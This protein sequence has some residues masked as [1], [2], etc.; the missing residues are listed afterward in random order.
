MD[1]KHGDGEVWKEGEGGRGPPDEMP[2]ATIKV[3]KE[4]LLQLFNSEP[5]LELYLLSVLVTF[6]LLS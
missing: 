1:L 6:V 4:I 3:T 5:Q 2:Q